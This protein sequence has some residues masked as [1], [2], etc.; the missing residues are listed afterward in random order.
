[1]L[2]RE[3]SVR[4]K[5]LLMATTATAIAIFAGYPATLLAQDTQP[6]AE[7]PAAD[8]DG[9][10]EE[11][12]VTAQR[13]DQ[14]LQDVPISVTALTETAIKSSGIT[15]TAAFNG[16]VPSLVVTQSGPSSLYFI[17]GAGSAIAAPNGEQA[18]AV[19]IDGVYIYS[20]VGN[21]FP[22]N[23]DIQRIEVLKGPQ[24][25]LFGRNATAG[26]IQVITKDPS[27]TP[28]LEASLSYGN[29]KTFTGDAYATMGIA[30]G[31]STSVSVYAKR[32]GD[33]YGTNLF[34]GSE[35]YKTD[36]TAVR[37]KWLW[38]PTET[39]QI[40]ASFAFTEVKGTNYE[41]QIMPGK[42]GL[43]GQVSNLKR[44]QT[45]T[46][47]PNAFIG[48]TYTGALQI[49]QELSFANLE[50]IVSYRSVPKA[51]Y[52]TDNEGSPLPIVNADVDE[53]SKTFTQELKLS[54]LPGAPFDW[55]TG[56]YYIR[57]KTGLTPLDLS[58]VAIATDGSHLYEF[59]TQT[60]KSLSF[61]GQA[62]FRLA[63]GLSVTGG[64]RYNF[65]KISHEGV[66]VEA[67][68]GNVLVPPVPGKQSD[69]TLNWRAAI[70]YQWSPTVMTYVS[71]TR[72]FK[73]GGYNLAAVPGTSLPPFDTEKLT[74]YE[75]GL[76]TE[77]FD[78]R[79]RF[80][81]AGYYYD[82]RNIQVQANF[83]AGQ[84]TSNGPKATIKGVE[85]ELEARLSRE[86][87]IR[88]GLNYL[89]GSYGNFPGAIGFTESPFNP[90]FEF[91]GRGRTSVYTP[92]WSGNISADYGVDTGIGRFTANANMNFRSAMFV[93]V[94]NRIR[95]PGYTVVNSSLSFTPN[96]G[97]FTVR[98]WALNL[99]D[100]RYLNYRTES[101]LGDYQVWAPPRTYGITLAVK[102]Q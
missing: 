6:Q 69:E 29:Y 7:A 88:G 25:T 40:R 63:E 5:P 84:I 98:V 85:A 1:M 61:F 57:G 54:S 23:N 42:L 53:P 34:D 21:I 68:L 13:R 31:L 97:P 18:V 26:V 89:D 59:D 10:L 24:G 17:R 67:P 4:S 72:S 2:I 92:R 64:L 90:S 96:D 102:I 70:D 46:N 56:F 44:F 39:T 80:N 27:A 15:N 28:S 12:V 73:S 50:N 33:G 58:G 22:I 38:A 99:F 62:T 36:Q 95:N 11:I 83:P 37:N 47:W 75:I 94:T 55:T 30:E 81:L 101:A 74:A 43:D 49:N 76:K 87:S 77:L 82:Y 9:G 66:S 14:R 100:E 32:M 3:K 45:N 79:L 8:R 71:A 19:Y 52:Q 51:L 60:L 91:N 65:E 20:P 48:R 35:I 41:L 16:M 93:A 86:F 78:R